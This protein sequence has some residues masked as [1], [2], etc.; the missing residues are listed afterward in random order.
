MKNPRRLGVSSHDGE[1]SEA[2]SLPRTGRL[3][4]FR[5]KCPFPLARPR[6][7]WYTMSSFATQRA[8]ARRGAEFDP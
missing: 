2:L 8:T 3:Q 7:I 6:G 4:L 1:R 5:E